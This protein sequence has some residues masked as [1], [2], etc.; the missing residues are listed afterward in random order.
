MGTNALTTIKYDGKK[1]ITNIFKRYDGCPSR[2]GI[3]QADFLAKVKKRYSKNE[4]VEPFEFER[5][6]NPEYFSY[7]DPSHLIAKMIGY[8]ISI[9]K[10]VDISLVENDFKTDTISYFYEIDLFYPELKPIIKC[11]D[12][13]KENKLFDGSPLEFLIASSLF[14][15]KQRSE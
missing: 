12:F 15:V 6:Q 4:M 7:D 3:L 9:E 2:W 5:N 13:R 11:Y 8:F 10:I 14:D 1:I